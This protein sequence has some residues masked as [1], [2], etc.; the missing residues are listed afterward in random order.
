MREILFVAITAIAIGIPAAHAQ[1]PLSA[2]VDANGYINVQKLTC[3]QLA[4]TYQQDADLLT[5][6]YSGWYNG[7]AHKHFLDY[8]KGKVAEHEVI[9]YCKEHPE[10]RVIDAI[11]VVF[12]DEAGGGRRRDEADSAGAAGGGEGAR[13]AAAKY[14]RLALAALA[15]A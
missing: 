15:S 13:T 2:Y 9:V 11:A 7:L 12:R 8:R 1:T 4:D 6:W 5:A 3:A 14:I 10:R